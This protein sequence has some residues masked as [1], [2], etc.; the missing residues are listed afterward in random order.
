VTK[1]LFDESHNELLRSQLTDDDDDED[2]DT[3]SELRKILTEELKYEVEV[4][5]PVSSETD[6]KCYDFERMGMTVI[7]TTKSYVVAD[8]KK[9]LTLTGHYRDFW[10]VNQETLQK[11]LQA[12]N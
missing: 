4:L 5:P 8:E 1:I 6:S 7:P 12:I 11:V 3:W 9:R 2:A 10:I